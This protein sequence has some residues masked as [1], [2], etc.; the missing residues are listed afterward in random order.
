MRSGDRRAWR[1]RCSLREIVNWESRFGASCHRDSCA[2]GE[3]AAVRDSA[4]CQARSPHSF[5]EAS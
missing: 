4:T 3:R 2:F 1:D 5:E